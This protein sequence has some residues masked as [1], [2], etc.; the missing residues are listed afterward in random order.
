[1][2]AVKAMIHDKDLPMYLW[3]EAA[4]TV[5]YV[6]NKSPHRVLE[7][8]TM[9]E[10]FSEDKPEVN[11]LRIFGSPV[12]VHVPKDKKTKL[13]PSRKKCIFV[14]YSDT[15]KTYI[16][17][18]L[19]HRNIDIS[20]DVTFDEDVSFHKSKKGRA[21]ESHDEENGVLRAAETR[22]LE[23]GESITEDKD[24]AKP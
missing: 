6:H 17:Y 10:M 24:M 19:G 15:S 3:A 14:E 11:H 23:A 9:K 22:E 16:V 21:E 5:V 8:K 20:R 4:M 7:N 13:D 12:Y 18:I 1:M 2:E